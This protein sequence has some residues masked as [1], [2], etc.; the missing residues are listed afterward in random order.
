MKTIHEAILAQ[1]YDRL[2]ALVRENP[3]LVHETDP[4]GIPMVFLAAKTGNPEMVRFFLE[5]T[6]VSMNM[7]DTHHRDI[8]HYAAMSGNVETCR[9]LVEKIGM[10]P[11]SG[12]LDLLTPYEIAARAGHTELTQYFEEVVGAPLSR[13]YKNPIRT[14][15]FPDPSILRVGDDYYMVNST[16]VFFPCIPV[17]H[18]KDLVHWRIIGH[19]ITNPEWAD[20]D[21]LTGGN[22][23]WAP[24]ISYHEGRFYI[25]VTYRHNDIGPVYRHQI[26][27]SS[28]RPEGPYSKPAVIDEDG[29]DPSLF[30]DDDGRRYMLLNRGARILELNQDATARI[31]DTQMLY[32]GDNKRNPEGPHLLKKDGYYYLIMAE[33]GTGQGHTVTAARSK[34]L[35]G[36]YEPC[37]FNPIM[38]QKDP[39]ARIQRCGH[40]D[41]VQT[42]NGQWYMPFL[43]GRKYLAQ[44]GSIRT[45]LGRETSMEPVT[46][47]ADGWPMANRL[48]GPSALQVRPDLPEVI[49]PP[50]AQIFD[51]ST[52]FHTWMFPRSPE[53]DGWRI[54][55]GKVT[56]KGSMD[57]LD[58]IHAKNILLRRQTSIHFTADCIMEIPPMCPGQNAGMVSYYDELTYIKF[59]VFCQEDGS[60]QMQVLEKIGPETLLHPSLKLPADLSRLW[61]RTVTRGFDR[62]L[63]FSFDGE[64]YIVAAHLPNADYL[65]DEGVPGKR[66]TGPLTGMY[67][68]AQDTPLYVTFD[69][70]YYLEE[71]HLCKTF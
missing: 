39:T 28:D 43:C 22:G 50:E 47:T 40:G 49:W 5:Y 62:V 71:D 59:G 53:P 33:G 34:T 66:F 58:S 32:Y 46:W 13:M 3:R 26:I 21:E 48:Q 55:D 9:Y 65:C 44:D 29:I 70:F 51:E 16:F 15:F 67:A 19:A 56:L 2:T 42:Q 27:V 8:L 35:R 63:E 6:G 68:H 31:S 64:A 37:P 41:L 18:S 30:T 1:D 36:T 17:S 25:T 24:D 10:S 11:V 69:Q 57:D 45:I 52:F 14:G 54:H 60:L 38:T 23:Y 4:Q 12:D 7:R 61:M 20:L